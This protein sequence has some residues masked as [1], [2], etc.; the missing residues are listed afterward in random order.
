MPNLIDPRYCCCAIPLV[1]AGIYA[2]LAEQAVSSAATAA[3]PLIMSAVVGAEVPS[4]VTYIFGI[5]C[6]VGVAVQPLGFFGVFREKTSTF[7][8]YSALNAIVHIAA[9]IVAAVIIIISALRHNTAVTNCE[10]DYFSANNQT[11]QIANSTLTDQGKTLCNAFAWADVGF[12]GG[13]WVILCITQLYFV[14]TARQY[15]VAQVSDHKLYHSVYSENPEAFTMSILQSRRYNPD[16]VMFQHPPRHSE[17]WD[18]RP[19]G[20]SGRHEPGPNTGSAYYGH[21]HS[22]SDGRGGDNGRYD[23]AEYANHPGPHD[24]YAFNS[25]GGGY[26]DPQYIHSTPG[27]HIHYNDSPAP[28]PPKP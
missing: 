13:L 21:Q 2:I 9:F 28:P 22:Y 23:D 1:N 10:V 24:N 26:V 17:A 7:R 11:T 4:F 5:V 18:H 8:W 20:E 15:S 14:I 27:P 16:S 6:F 12:M 25:P 3:Q 19:S